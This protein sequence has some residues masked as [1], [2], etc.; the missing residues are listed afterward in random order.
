MSKPCN[1]CAKNV[2]AIKFP[3]L[4]CVHCK[5]FFHAKCAGLCDSSFQVIQADQLSWTCQICKRR[6]SIIVPCASP[7]Q[8]PAKSPTHLQVPSP[9][10]LRDLSPPSAATS[11]KPS[12]ASVSCA[13]PSKLVQLEQKLIQ[14]SSQISELVELLRSTQSR[15]DI[16]EAQLATKLSSVDSLSTKLADL[17]H[18]S[19]QVECQLSGDKLEIQGLPTEALN[20]PLAAIVSIGESINCPISRED[21][22]VDPVRF[23]SRLSVV[24]KLRSL[25]N[26]FLFA[27]KA[28]NRANKRFEWKQR[29]HKIHVNEELSSSQKKLFR[30]TK[31]FA[32]T[33]G[34]K[35]VWV[36]LNGKIYLKKSENIP[37]VIV[38]SPSSLRDENLLPKLSR[39]ADEIATG[40]SS[41]QS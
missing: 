21:L 18:K 20:D 6:S 28:F 5:K 12:G 25:R 8:A 30:D 39:S 23:S 3:G 13:Q 14:Q 17:E 9:S 2:T 35:F 16:L 4:S 33:H 34:Y 38:D 29:H 24:F 15:V 11:I 22:V 1:K 27:G 19:D 7:S 32:T 40:P 36:G 31:N 26:N 10:R 41:S 37:P